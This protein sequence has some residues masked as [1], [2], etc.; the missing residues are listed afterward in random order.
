MRVDRGKA[1]EWMDRASAG[2]DA[3]FASLAAAT[4]DELFRLFLA[5]GLGRADAAEA[6]QETFL[7]AYR[8]RR[9]WRAGGDAA[10]WL[11]GIAMN[12]AREFRRSRRRRPAAGIDLDALAGGTTGDG[13]AA[14]ALRAELARLAAAVDRLPRR[15]REA[16]T[17]RYLRQF[18]VR[19]T[20]AV[21]GCAEG[22]V[23]AATAAALEN[24]KRLMGPGQ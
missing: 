10:A 12:V 17:C 16:L 6:V 11:G 14:A 1:G 18:S 24:L 22:T 3:A 19:Q 8:R 15:Q 13:P 7:R 2:D 21:M 23:K 9:A 20:A 4:Q 5:G